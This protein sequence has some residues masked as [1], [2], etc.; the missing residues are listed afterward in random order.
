MLKSELDS[1]SEMGSNIG[2]KP[3]RKVRK[4][5]ELASYDKAV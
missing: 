2:F 1:D 5:Y 4:G 3:L